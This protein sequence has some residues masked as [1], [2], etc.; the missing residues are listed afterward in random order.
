MDQLTARRDRLV[1]ALL[2]EV[3]LDVTA[4]SLARGVSAVLGIDSAAINV[5]DPDGGASVAAAHG[6][7]AVELEMLQRGLGDGPTLSAIAGGRLVVSLDPEEW[8]AR[9]PAFGPRSATM[10]VSGLFS[11]PLRPRRAT[12]AVLSM[13]ATDARG[14]DAT[15]VGDVLLAADL[16]A[17]ALADPSAGTLEGRLRHVGDD[18]ATVHHAAGVLVA[19]Q[20]LDPAQALSSLRTAAAGT[21]SALADVAAEVVR[22]DPAP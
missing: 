3:G 14:F 22:A 1:P 10:G 2:A 5:A 13:Y 19:R 15:R 17:E 16:V 18:R 6:P 7:L 12:A 4:A 9:W 21:G 20:G 11:V 8:S